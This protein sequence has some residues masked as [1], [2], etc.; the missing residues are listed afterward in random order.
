MTEDKE[1]PEKEPDKL[2]QSGERDGNGRFLPGHEGKG[3]RPS[4]SITALIKQKLNEV[5]PGQMKTYGEQVVEKIMEKA[6][7]NGDVTLLKEIW[8]Y[9]DGAPRQTVAIDADKESLETL[10]NFFREVGAA[11]NVKKDAEPKID[12]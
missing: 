1:N 4:F 2:V 3:G 11:K 12:N 7:V 10:T 9:M 6:Y 5:P 8:H